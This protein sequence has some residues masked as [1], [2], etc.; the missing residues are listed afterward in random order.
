MASPGLWEE[1]MRKSNQRGGAK[2]IPHLLFQLP[3]AMIT[4]Q[5]V[6]IAVYIEHG[7]DKGITTVGP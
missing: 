7:S 1:D 3:S 6:D 4:I 2:V 5:A